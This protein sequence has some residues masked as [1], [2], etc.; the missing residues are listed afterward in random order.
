MSPHRTPALTSRL[1][2]RRTAWLVALVPLLRRA[3]ASS[4]WCPR[5]TARARPPTTC[6]Q[7]A[8]STQARRAARRSCPRT[9][10]RSRSCC[11][12]PTTASSTRRPGRPRPAGRRPAV[13]GRRGT[14]RG[15]RRRTAAGPAG[16]RPRARRAAA[17]VPGDRVRG[18]HRRHRR[19]P[20][21][22]P[23]RPPTTSTRSSELRDQLAR[24]RARRG[25][26][27]R[28]PGPAGIQADLGQ[29]FD[30]ADIR[31]LLA[32]AGVVAL[33]LII[34]Y[35][36]PVL[37]LVPLI[38]VG[39]ADRLAAIVATNVL[40]VARRR[41][42]RVDGR[43]PERA[44]LRRRHRLRPAADLPLP[45]RAQ[46]HRVALRGDGARAVRRTTEAV[47]SSAT[48]VVLGLLTLLLSVVPTTRGL[49][50]ACAVGVV[51]AA[52]FALVVLPAALVLFGRWVFWPRVPHV[53]RPGPGRVRLA[54]APRRRPAVARRPRDLRRRH[55]GRARRPGHRRPVDHHRP[56][57]GRP[58]PRSAPRRS[59][60]PSGSASPSP[61]APATRSRSLTR[62]D[63]RAGAGRRRGGRRG[64]LRAASPA[65]RRDHPHRRRASTPRPAATPPR[66]SCSTLR[67]AVADFDDTHVGG[68]DAEAIDAARQR[69]ERPAADPAAHP[70][71]GARRAARAAALGRGAAAARR[72]RA[73]RRT[74]RAWASSWWLFTRVV[75]L[76]G[77]GHRGAAAGV[78]VPRGARRRLQHLPGHPGPRGGARARHPHRA[79]C[80]PSPPPAA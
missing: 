12:P 73:W 18:R 28:S 38:V 9:R 65:G 40:E 13:E 48:T 75:R 59:R 6:P 64:R 31:L 19:R 37:W 36:S 16:R 68:A 34:T 66:R 70:A 56:R 24:R 26:P 11:G 60:P 55:R 10:A 54:L 32:T 33:L 67:D 51:V 79:C 62:D 74:P 2:G 58:V 17:A 61:P 47:L 72:D 71:A 76:R 27:S 5:A 1:A 57:P 78:P 39:I 35:R 4:R 7:G 45:R 69:R 53:G 43:H 15:A 22:R 44:R 23:P 52:T 30:G 3:G 41:L 63:A 25:R 80:A 49:G 50:L 14:G 29:V 20:R 77:D 46:D 8:D 21:R 42:G